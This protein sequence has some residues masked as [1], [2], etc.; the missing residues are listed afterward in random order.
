MLRTCF[1][2]TTLWFALCACGAGTNAETRKTGTGDAV[3]TNRLVREIRIT[4]QPEAMKRLQRDTREYVSATLREGPNTFTNIGIH[5]KGTGSFRPLDQKP[6]FTVKFN[7][8]VDGQ[9]FYGLTKVSL[10]NCVQDPTYINEKLCS[11]LFSSIGV[12]AARV[13][14]VRV[15]LNERYLGLYTLVE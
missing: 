3:F 2:A 12:P 13:T 8:F 14:H 7:K 5:L 1:I 10:N 9:N 15:H 6:A 4:I 11:E